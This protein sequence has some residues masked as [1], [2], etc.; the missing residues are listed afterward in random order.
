MFITSK[1]NQFFTFGKRM[2]WVRAQRSLVIRFWRAV[3]SETAQIGESWLLKWVMRVGCVSRGKA[4]GAG[5]RWRESWLTG[6]FHKWSHNLIMSPRER[7]LLR[8]DLNVRVSLFSPVTLSPDLG[9]RRQFYTFREK[10][11]QGSLVREFMCA[12]VLVL[13]RRTRLFYGCMCVCVRECERCVGYP[14]IARLREWCSLFYETRKGGSFGDYRPA[15]G[16]W[17][18]CGK[19]PAGSFWYLSAVV[20]L[21]IWYG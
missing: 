5:D 17:G 14:N 19:C 4:L 10:R 3:S 20:M 11:A 18:T 7:S 21:I 6:D 15:Q 12:C 8:L 16:S 1:S 2:K 9:I 13:V